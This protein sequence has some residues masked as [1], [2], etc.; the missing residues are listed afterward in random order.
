MAISYIGADVDCKMTE[1]AVE[2]RGKIVQRDR[3]LTDVKS[4][5][6]FL[7]S[8]SGRKVMIIEECPMSGWLYRN[9]RTYVEK[10]VVCCVTAMV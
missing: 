8:V 1:L 6:T 2:Q 7:A 4:L 3:V 9:L 5:R 10:F